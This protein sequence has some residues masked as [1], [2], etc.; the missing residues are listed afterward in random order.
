MLQWPCVLETYQ[1][2]PASSTEMTACAAAP[3]APREPSL[4][5]PAPPRT[6]PTPRRVSFSTSPKHNDCSW[7]RHCKMEQL[8][9][10]PPTG[11]DYLSLRVKGKPGASGVATLQSARAPD[12]TRQFMSDA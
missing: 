10:P 1:E 9:A 12:S 7:Y 6:S 2:Q 8:Y 4:S 5:P 3:A 11:L